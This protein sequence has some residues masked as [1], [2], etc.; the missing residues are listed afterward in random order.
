MKRILD[1]YFCWRDLAIDDVVKVSSLH[2]ERVRVLL[3]LHC[4]LIAVCF[5]HLPPYFTFLCVFVQRLAVSL[6]STKWL[7]SGIVVAVHRFYGQVKVG[8]YAKAADPNCDLLHICGDAPQHACT[9]SSPDVCL[10]AELVGWHCRPAVC[11]S[12]YMCTLHSIVL[13]RRWKFLNVPESD[14]RSCSGRSSCARPQRS[15][16]HRLEADL[17]E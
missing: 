1:V 15:R 5:V 10:F 13:C 11:V 9:L 7:P 3:Q 17:L 8:T 4:N 6:S 2:I 16:H 12:T 14:T